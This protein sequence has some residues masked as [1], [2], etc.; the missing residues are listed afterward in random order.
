MFVFVLFMYS[1]SDRV[2]EGTKSKTAIWS[3]SNMFASKGEASMV[4]ASAKFP[5]KAVPK[6]QR[7]V[8]NT[9]VSSCFGL[10]IKSSIQSFLL[11]RLTSFLL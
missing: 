5:I 2:E 7:Q 10:F 11:R 1:V 6:K 3:S 4:V 9:V 8:E